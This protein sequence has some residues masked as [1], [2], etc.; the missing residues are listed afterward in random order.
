MAE[1]MELTTEGLGDLVA[2]IVNA[3]LDKR[4]KSK[5]KD[6]TIP[7]GTE[8]ADLLALSR[9]ELRNAFGRTMR[10]LAATKGSAQAGIHYARD[11]WGTG[12]SDPATKILISGSDTAG[13]F[14]VPDVLSDIWLEFLEPESIFMSLGP[15]MIPFESG[16]STMNGLATGATAYYL[17]EID[18]ITAS[19]VAFRSINISAKQLAAL[20]P[21]SNYL[22]KVSGV[23]VDSIVS[24]NMFSTIGKRQDL[25]YIR[26]DG[27]NDTPIGVRNLGT[28]TA[29]T[30]TPTLITTLADLDNAEYRM[31]LVDS[32]MRKLGW[33]F[34]PRITK[35]LKGL[36]NLVGAYQFRDEM[37]KGTLNGFP[38]KETTQIPINLGGGTETEVYLGDF[39]E[40]YAGDTFGVEMSVSTE[41]SY[42]DGGSTFSAFQKNMTLMKAVTAHD[43]DISHANAVQIITGV[44][45]GA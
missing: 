34:H 25:A 13:G 30:A 45:W 11:V 29:M 22:L 14:T 9:P 39:D 28:A 38:W 41:A 18:A 2:G 20:V 21:I 27:I 32:N 33:M 1:I 7:I 35:W 36:V 44:T 24:D 17:G 23:S 31:R 8:K 16:N 5:P 4:D 6:I 42:V 43:M 3:A 15:R 26:G 10:L 19:E 40:I 12:D 37:N